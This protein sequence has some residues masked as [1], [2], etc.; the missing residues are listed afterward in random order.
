[1]PAHKV[2]C[3]VDVAEP[4]TRFPNGT[5]KTLP[6]VARNLAPRRHDLGISSLRISRAN[7]MLDHRAAVIAL[8]DYAV[9]FT[10]MI[11]VNRAPTPASRRQLA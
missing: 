9:G 5:D 6:T 2:S 1:M 8:G 3:A 11:G 10:L 4:V 7:H